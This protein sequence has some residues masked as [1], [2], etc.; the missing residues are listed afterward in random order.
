M[1]IRSSTDFPNVNNQN[2]FLVSTHFI[3]SYFLDLN[4]SSLSSAPLK[5]AMEAKR[6][7]TRTL[8][9]SKIDEVQI[10]LDDAVSRKAYDE[11]A[12][13]QRELD[14]LAR[15]RA[16]IPTIA[17]LSGALR[18]AEAKVADAAANR[19]FS[20]AASF[21]AAVDAARGR[22]EQALEAE[23]LSYEDIEEEKK[24][25]ESIQFSSRAEL[26]TEISTVKAKIEES[27]S[28]K[29]FKTA[30]ALQGTVDSLEVLREQLP[31]IPELEA[32]I[33][34]MKADM[35]KAI[36][37]KNFAKAESIQSDIDMIE[38]KLKVEKEQCVEIDT[39]TKDCKS[40]SA[41]IVDENG[42]RIEFTSRTNLEK[43][44]ASVSIQLSKTIAE[45]DFKKAPVIQAV[46][47]KLESLRLLLPT[48]TEMRKSLAE[49]KKEMQTA[50]STK[51]Y[52]KAEEIQGII[53]AVEKNLKTEM[54]NEKENPLSSKMFGTKTPKKGTTKLMA[55]S[56]NQKGV[57]PASVKK[58]RIQ[59]TP[60][61]LSMRGGTQSKKDNRTVSKLRPKKPMIAG[62][63]DDVLSVCQMLSNKRGD[64]ALI[65]G[66]NGGLAGIITDTDITRRVVAKHLDPASTGVSEVMTANPTC[67]A[68]SDSAMDALGTMVDNHFRHLPVVD[69]SGAVVG[70]LDIAKCLNDAISKLEKAQDKSS[71]AADDAIKQMA[72]LQ[73]AGG[74]Q[75]EMMTQ[76]LG[77]IMAQ[78]FGG[79]SSPTLRSLLAGKPATV[80]S[81]GTNLRDTGLV[82]TDARKAALVVEDDEVVGIFGF[83]DMMSRAIA[84]ELPL[85]LTAVSS[86][87]TPNP[88][89]VTPDTTV[90][91]ALQI[92]HDNRFLT[93]PVCEADGSVVGL[94]GVM[95]LVYGAGGADG[96]RSI[97][98]G[99]MDLA[100]DASDRQSVT[101]QSISKATRG[102]GRMTIPDTP[103]SK[104]STKKVPMHVEIED[105]HSL[106]ES[107]THDFRTKR[108]EG[109]ISFGPLGSTLQSIRSIDSSHTV[110]KIVDSDGENYRVRC[111][112]K[113]S[114][115]ISSL[116]EKIGGNVNDSAIVL[117]FI[118][119]EGDAIAVSTDS[120]LIEA[121]E[122]S[123]KAGHQAVKLSL[124]IQGSG[125]LAG[126][127]NDKTLLMAGAGA[128]F[129]LFVGLAIALKPKN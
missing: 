52:S 85:E 92:M 124:A 31:S 126:V 14:K 105:G 99:A 104:R 93:L 59:P 91:E 36:K 46:L 102:N 25:E 39:D 37:N 20:A 118:D 89:S 12:P 128:A 17:E 32:K 87:M 30:S 76:L 50:I 10:K 86:V 22:L 65:T 120:D 108:D 19:N 88:E 103:L 35:D 47:D 2:R 115:L 7:L 109:N 68:M 55:L 96:W 34:A 57:I 40:D 62:V 29:D 1:S 27:I 16:D 5:E 116:K 53:D 33:S 69:D 63:E 75:A 113:Y 60:A 81:P 106:G 44:I 117:K 21:K 112:H 64:A 125:G 67:V 45:K 95:D 49:L 77:G 42:E 54:E 94:V 107:L 66:V 9:E 123:R 23:G 48:V 101:S 114:D 80:V 6:P 111:E 122:N 90:L 73:G 98:D 24:E 129:A 43:K 58:S 61:K 127:A 38:E 71:N 51:D 78:A 74:A 79:K 13:L 72:A 110:F 97:F 100:D 3:F 11:C 26:E 28:S 18:A 70:L 84:K 82:M 41:I 83:K 121:I 56:T 15:K 119:D 8:L 4:F